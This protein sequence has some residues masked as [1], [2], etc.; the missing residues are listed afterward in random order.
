MLTIWLSL[1]CVGNKFIESC[2]MTGVVM[3]GCI[4]C[5]ELF[6]GSIRWT[7]HWRMDGMAM[8]RLT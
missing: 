3:V 2:T 8:V 4:R 1:R 5:V 7:L 6:W